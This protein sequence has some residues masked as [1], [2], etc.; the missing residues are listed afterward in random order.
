MS[1]KP[2]QTTSTEPSF[3]EQIILHAPLSLLY[4]KY[5]L[6]SVIT[7]VFFGLQSLVDGYIAGNYIGAYALGG[8][9]IV[10]PIFSL[11]MVVS[12][13]IGIGCQTLIGHGLGAGNRLMAQRAMSTGLWAL[14]ALALLGTVVLMIFAQE[15]VVWMGADD[16]LSPYAVDYLRGLAPFM[17]PMSICFYSD[18]M[19]KAMG[20]PIYSSI[21][22]GSA[23]LL[24]IALGV[25]FV[26][27][28]ELGTYG[29]AISTGIA[30]SCALVVSGWKT[31]DPRQSISMLK[32]RFEMA[33]LK[34]ALFNGASEGV[35]ELA[36]GLSMLIINLL[37]MQ[38]L[39]A[40]GVSAY[41]TLNYLNFIGILLFLGISDGLIPVMSFLYGA[42]YRKRLLS[43]V[44]STLII[45]AIIGLGVFGGLMLGGHH[46]IHIFLSDEG[47]TTFRLASEG[48]Q[49]YAFVFLLSGFNI[50]VTSFFTAIGNAVG[51]II[52]A[53]LRGL[54]F[55]VIG[56]LSLPYIWGDL[57]LWLSIPLAELLTLVVALYLLSR[58]LK[59]LMGNTKTGNR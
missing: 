16:T 18:L 7:M 10:S 31:F 47:T 17:I 43:I 35:S 12:L 50:F 21:V 24:N 56:M 22:M 51:S 13:S 57:G 58:R 26:I 32:G 3:Q 59:L 34:R 2:S 41:T 28:L 9:N 29:T 38:R 23:V 1:Y 30:F 25:Y 27:Y 5:A 39:G 52:I 53:L 55:L 19:L 42:Q 36:A 4:K 15:I 54:V 33:L 14:S 44:R 37:V 11:L 6:P 45:N 46:F 8:T 49:V 48:L 20:H 40:E